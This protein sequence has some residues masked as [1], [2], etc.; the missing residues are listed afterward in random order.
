MGEL[1]PLQGVS[2][3]HQPAVLFTATAVVCVGNLHKHKDP[4]KV[5]SYSPA[6]YSIL[7]KE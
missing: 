3:N 6:S 4:G 1:T 5:S 7:A 2:I